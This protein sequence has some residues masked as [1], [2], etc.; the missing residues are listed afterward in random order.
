MSLLIL[1]YQIICQCFVLLKVA[2]DVT[3][4]QAEG[5][6]VKIHNIIFP[7][8]FTK[9]MIHS[10]KAG[11]TFPYP[12]KQRSGKMNHFS[13][14][15]PSHALNCLVVFFLPQVIHQVDKKFLACLINTT[16]SSE[17]EGMIYIYTLIRCPLFGLR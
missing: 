4:C 9:E 2:V 6:A 7:Y 15:I 12:F 5:L 17:N 8:R 1:H 11:L 13:S 16:E 14:R 3:S 10:M